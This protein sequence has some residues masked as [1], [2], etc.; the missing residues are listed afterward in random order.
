MFS[1]VGN[2]LFTKRR[3]VQTN[4]LFTKRILGANNLLEILL[5]VVPRWKKNNSAREW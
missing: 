2:K 4:N 1:K 3:M 5:L